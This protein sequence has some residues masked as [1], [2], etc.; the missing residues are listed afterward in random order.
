MLWW[1]L[2]RLK[3]KSRS[4]R[5]AAAVKLGES[6]TRRVVPA[7]LKAL[8]DEDAAVRIAASRG[9]ASIPHAA[10]VEPL[11]SALERAAGTRLGKTETGQEEYKAL[12]EALAVQGGEAVPFLSR[13][14]GS[15][16]HSSR[17]WA[18]WA[19]GRIGG[20]E[21]ATALAGVLED[22]RSEV[23]QQAAAA[24]GEIADPAVA[25][26]LV[27]ALSH[28]DPDTRRAAATALGGFNEERV[29]AALESCTRDIDEGVQRAAVAGLARIGTV[30]AALR[31]RAA[32]ESERRAVREA[33]LTAAKSPSLK[34]RDARE[35]VALAVLRGDY[36]AAATEGEV[37]LPA[38][39]DA[40]QSK[41]TERRAGA[42]RA[43]ERLRSVD[44]IQSLVHALRD[45]ARSVRASA[46]DSLV[47]A[48]HHAVG[49]LAE[50]LSSE[51]VGVQIHAAAAL[52][53]I[54]DQRA[55]T[56][57][58]ALIRRNG[59]SAAG[60][61]GPVEAARSAAEALKL[62]LQQNAASLSEEELRSL[63]DV[64]DAVVERQ[65]PEDPYTTLDENAVD[66]AP[67][68]ALAQRELSR[69]L[70]WS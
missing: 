35:A 63:G 66:C 56:A 25:D 12:A 22:R 1:A 30:A 15:P 28:R 43:L 49:A 13:L 6:R 46:E 37:A 18:S 32:V 33:A 5:I 54:G 26:A 3:S 62:I 39:L 24:L 40:I 64:P 11:A 27:K 44:A 38:L 17:L 47:A 59:R 53:R 58:A 21:A 29:L 52:G 31:L 4:A 7:L 45:P 9:L 19:L 48:G 61:D 8:E 10:A 68:R 34:P 36:A 67:V 70:G 2:H 51:D 41:D 42:V 20:A 69:R 55:V 14:L 50:A 57:L 23:R 60:Y 16:H 65:S